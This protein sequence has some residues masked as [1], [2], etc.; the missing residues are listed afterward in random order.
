MGK[1]IYGILAPLIR[2]FTPRMDTVWDVPFDG[3]PCIFVGNH[4]RANGPISA[5]VKFPLRKHCY[6]WIYANAMD[7]KL[8]PAYVRQD[9]W[10]DP[11]DRLA[12]LYDK[13]IPYI[14]ALLLPPILKSVPNVPVYHGAR[15][16]TTLR[17]SVKLLEK[18]ESLFIFP[19][20]PDGYKSH[21][22]TRINEGFLYLLPMVYKKTGK[23]IR[24]WPMHLDRHAF[25]VRAPILFD[26]ER[27][28]QEQIPDLCR[29][30]SDGIEENN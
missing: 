10:W 1:I 20:I 27:P 24:I 17:E 5:A 13:T 7:R 8:V 28:L 15:A 19:G 11:K 29:R 2:A 25:H 18:G 16:M 23:V 30:I 14:T 3:E 21:S 12:P 26:P 6:I 4:D 9:Y 22:G